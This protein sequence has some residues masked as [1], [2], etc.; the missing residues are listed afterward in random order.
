MEEEELNRIKIQSAYSLPSQVS[1]VPA[2][3]ACYVYIEINSLTAD[4]QDEDGI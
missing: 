1:D 2:P 4:P 3:T